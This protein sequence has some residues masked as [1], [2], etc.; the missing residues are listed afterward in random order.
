M[1]I[2][3]WR[4]HGLV[5]GDSHARSCCGPS[6]GVVKE[7]EHGGLEVLAV[8]CSG[9]DGVTRA[10]GCE[11]REK[12]KARLNLRSEVP[13]NRGWGQDLWRPQDRNGQ[14]IQREVR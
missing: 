9:Y 4:T 14:A 10:T 8:P 7:A 12:R 2:E 1:E 13:W 3:T 11:T 6:S 5:W